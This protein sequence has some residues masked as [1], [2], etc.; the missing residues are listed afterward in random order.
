M[1]GR[2]LRAQLRAQQGRNSQLRPGAG[3]PAEVARVS[4]AAPPPEGPTP[5]VTSEA[6]R[7]RVEAFLDANPN[8]RRAIFTDSAADADSVIVTVG[9]R[10]KATS[11][12]LIPRANYDPLK[13]MQVM[14]E[15]AESA[16]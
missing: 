15:Y 9:L 4:K 6:R 13:L 7:L 10:G 1:T 5:D 16:G 14:D 2:E 8:V 12:V 11:E 3:G